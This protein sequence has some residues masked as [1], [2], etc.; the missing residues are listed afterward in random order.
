[1]GDK[2]SS[3]KIVLWRKMTSTN[4]SN[5]DSGVFIAANSAANIFLFVIFVLPAL[6]LCV[7]C[8]VSL[9][10]A[11]SINWP[12]RIALINIFAG[13][14]CYWFSV[15]V[16]YLGFPA[17]ALSLTG[18]DFSC[19][20][21]LSLFLLSASQ[22]YIA[23]ALYAIMV[24]IFL[25]Y[26]VRK[27]KLR[28]I[29]FY[30]A[31]SWIYVSLLASL[32]YIPGFED[33]V[34]EHGFCGS[35]DLEFSGLL[36][37]IPAVFSSAVDILFLCLIV[38]FGVLSFCYVK[39]NTL[40][41]NVEIKRA[42]T[43]NLVYLFVAAVL[44]FAYSYLPLSYV[45]IREALQDTEVVSIVVVEYLI[46]PFLYLPTIAT[47]VMAIIL[48]KAVRQAMGEVLKRVCACKRNRVPSPEE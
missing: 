6:I 7:F 34:L 27:F 25:R 4:L 43:K 26:G 22:R 30:I 10:L 2:V 36:F 3:V 45:A 16:Q 44:S 33:V 47:P 9:F 18:A 12:L 20:I 40:E 23:I 29:M 21:V 19:R 31:A 13:E 37:T 1:M 39:K 11:Y 17:R 28:A 8:V 41:S 5:L 24:Y 35:E 42:I 32:P 48:L 14:I 38:I 46:S 15:T